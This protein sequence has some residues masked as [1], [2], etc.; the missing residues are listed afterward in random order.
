MNSE[1][2]YFNEL[3]SNWRKSLPK[4]HEK[5]L[6]EIFPEA[7]SVIEKMIIDLQEEKGVI[8]VHLKDK[9]TIIKQSKADDFSKWFC[10][11]WLKISEGS[12]LV[13]IENNIG[14]LKRIVSENNFNMKNWVCEK[15]IEQAMQVPIESLISEKLKK[16]GKTLC[17]LC[18]LHN[19]KHA[20]FYIYP[21]TNSF[22]CFGCNQGGNAINFAKLLHGYSFKEA[23]E[24]LNK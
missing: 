8:L 20:S 24:F 22:Y 11:E 19:E 10:R 18:P 21:E 17:G 6:L 16:M 14:R 23:V 7:E 13:E 12:R 2:E 5:V 15:Q 4:L 9:L 3:E 1:K